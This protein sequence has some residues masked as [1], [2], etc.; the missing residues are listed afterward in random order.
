MIFWLDIK[1]RSVYLR[2]QKYDLTNGN[3]L[4]K[5]LLVAVPIMGAQLLQMSYNLMDMFWLGQLPK[6]ADAVAAAG[7]AGMFMW[8]GVALML[9]G[10]MG[11]EIGVSQ[12]LGKGDQDEAKRY[13]QI[14]VIL[15]AV[16]GILYGIVQFFF[17][18]WLISFFQ[19]REV[20]VAADA[21]AYLSIVGIA[22]PL[23]Y[24]GSAIAGTFNGSGNSRLSFIG[25]SISLILNMILTPVFVHVL[26]R[27][28]TGAAE[29]TVIA[30][31]VYLVTMI[32]LLK[33][34]KDRPFDKIKLFVKPKIAV[35]KQIFKWCL[36][37]SA[38]SMFF[39]ILSM[40][41]TR[42]VTPFGS[43]ALAVLRV[44]GQIES[45]QWLIAGGFGS[46][47]T[48]FTGQNYGAKKW[49]RIH[50][51]RK[52]SF[53]AMTVYGVFVTFVLFF[54]SYQLIGIFLHEEPV[55]LMGVAYLQILAMCQLAGCLEGVSAG[56]LRGMG[57]TLPPSI[58]SISVNAARV[59]LSYILTLT[60]LGLNGIWV[61]ITIG[62]AVR[63]ILMV[64]W[65]QIDA[66]KRPKTDEA[67]L[68]AQA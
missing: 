48:A 46:A 58:I 24:V 53:L 19:I 15:A 34:H 62:A 16:L 38:E 12:S 52:I 68:L 60:P 21:A 23:M 25:I 10:R 28:V 20:N 67:D 6:G 1:K 7:S 55:I 26:D 51:G 41:I 59:P 5:L 11:S 57:K 54:F 4:S 22:T 40:L 9:V 14:S 18:P 47:I 30:Q 31:A 45:L 56:I 44:G 64:I 63:G 42:L 50:R 2:A 32:Y 65:C 37:V 33:F 27:G 36:P 3:I 29:S 43:D 39:T 8:L 17:A 61:G 13:A 66:R 49:A 35:V